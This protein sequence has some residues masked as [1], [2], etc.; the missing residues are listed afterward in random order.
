[1]PLYVFRGTA[2]LDY[3][4]GI[5]AEGPEEAKALWE[6]ARDEGDFD[7]AVVG[8]VMDAEFSSFDFEFVGTPGN[9]GLRENEVEDWTENAHMALGRIELRKQLRERQRTEAVSA[10]YDAARDFAK[11]ASG[12]HSGE[13]PNES[14]R[15]T[16]PSL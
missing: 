15:V 2:Q 16:G 8:A 1:M 3:D 12:A 13:N 5:E 11:K 6:A 9:L 10:S 7:D 4:F 14:A